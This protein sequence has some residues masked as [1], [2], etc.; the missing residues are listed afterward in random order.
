M[1]F[2]IGRAWADAVALL[3]ER[4]LDLLLVS[5]AI[6]VIAAAA[7][8]PFASQWLELMQP[9]ADP[10]VQVARMMQVAP[11]IMGLSM[12]ANLIQLA[13]WGAMVALLGPERPNLGKALVAGLKATPTMLVAIIFLF[14]SFYIA[15]IAV[16]LVVVGL[17]AGLAATQDNGGSAA[18]AGLAIFAFLLLY[19]GGLAG[20]LYLALRFV[21]LAPVV[22]LERQYN[23]FTVLTR[24]WASTRGN[25]WKIVVMFLLLLIPAMFVLV[26]AI[27]AF[28]P[29]F[30][31][32]E[33]G[34]P[35]FE[36]FVPIWL[37]AIPLN[38][39]LTVLMVAITVAIHRQLSAEAPAQA[40]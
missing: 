40:E 16:L 3:R 7:M 12:L 1:T 29:P 32:M 14:V 20:V 8:I 30:I 39:A 33:G 2:S 35:R 17:I 19:F 25:G 15:L 11:R 13:G 5:L 4:W 21:T 24:T 34:V 37:T 23:P 6:H 31:T 9:S 10:E 38:I 22:V 26:A 28:L 18:G 27:F 36:S